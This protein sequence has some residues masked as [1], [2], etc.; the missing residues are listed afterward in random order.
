MSSCTKISYRQEQRQSYNISHSLHSQP[1]YVIEASDGVVRVDMDVIAVT[2]GL[3]E[4]CKR[5]P[6]IP[7]RRYTR[8]C[9]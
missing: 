6:P 5:A 1:R 2:A 9:A 4:R 3:F 7:V 8:E